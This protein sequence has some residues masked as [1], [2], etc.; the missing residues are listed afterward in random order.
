MHDHKG[1]GSIENSLLYFHILVT[2]KKIVYHGLAQL[3]TKPNY[4]TRVV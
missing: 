2:I 3:K 4:F 1:F